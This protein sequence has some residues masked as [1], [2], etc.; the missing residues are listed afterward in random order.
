MKSLDRGAY[1]VSVV[2]ATSHGKKKI[3]LS[4]PETQLTILIADPDVHTYYN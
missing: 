2:H 1:T 3:S 4:P